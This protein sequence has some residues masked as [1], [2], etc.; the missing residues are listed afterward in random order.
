MTAGGAPG[1][2]LGGGGG[3]GGDADSLPLQPET[4]GIPHAP[5]GSY[6]ASGDEAISRVEATRGCAA[7]RW[8]AG[9]VARLCTKRDSRFSRFFDSS[10]TWA[11]CCVR[12]HVPSQR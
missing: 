12:R 10:S 9:G 8:V 11:R 2:W 3:G 4:G 6:P 1:S 7:K 5:L